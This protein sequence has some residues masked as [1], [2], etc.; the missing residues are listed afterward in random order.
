MF[1]PTRRNAY[2]RAVEVEGIQD[3]PA[4]LSVPSRFSVSVP[5]PR[6]ILC[7]SYYDFERC[8]HI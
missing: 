4:D 8:N 1:L 6:E 5:M 3:G 2:Q 7:A